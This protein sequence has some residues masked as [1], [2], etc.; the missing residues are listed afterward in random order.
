MDENK[1]HKK[2]KTETSSRTLALNDPATSYWL[3]DAIR[4]ALKRDSVDAINDA[5]W[6]ATVQ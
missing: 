5:G 1:E 2:M 3:K 4:S 6:I